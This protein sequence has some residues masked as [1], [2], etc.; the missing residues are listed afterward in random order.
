VWERETTKKGGTDLDEDVLSLSV[1][2]SECVGTEAGHV[3]PSDGSSVVRELGEGRTKDGRR[4][5]ESGQHR[6][7]RKGTRDG[8]VEGGNLRA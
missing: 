6:R 1:G 5:D 7:L 4:K 3:P 8:M 2:P